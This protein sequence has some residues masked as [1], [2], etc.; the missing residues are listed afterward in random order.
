MAVDRAGHQV[1]RQKCTDIA[2]QEEACSKEGGGFPDIPIFGSNAFDIQGA[3]EEVVWTF[4]LD[5]V[6]RIGLL[7]VTVESI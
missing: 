4:V 2:A 5:V 1:C 6:V 7:G 3:S